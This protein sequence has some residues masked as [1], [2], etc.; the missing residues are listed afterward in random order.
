MRLHVDELLDFAKKLAACHLSADFTW[1]F[2][3]QVIAFE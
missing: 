2:V 3:Y 1:P